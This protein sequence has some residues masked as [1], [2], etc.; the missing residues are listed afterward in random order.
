MK[1]HLIENHRRERVISKDENLWESGY[2]TISE[3]KAKSLIGGDLYLHSKQTNPSRFGGIIQGYRFV[4]EGEFE[5]KVIF[6]F[7][8]TPDH[9]G[10]KTD[11]KGWGNEQKTDPN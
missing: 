3:E 2:W 6:S 9:K 10:F 4:S 11:K 8:F 7:V 1:I 5:G